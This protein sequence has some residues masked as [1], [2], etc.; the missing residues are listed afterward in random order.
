MVWM[1]YSVDR[2]LTKEPCRWM[3]AKI[4]LRKNRPVRYQCAVMERL[5]S[6]FLY[7]T[8]SACTRRDPP[9]P[10]VAPPLKTKFS[11]DFDE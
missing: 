11:H 7:N 4:S 3:D 5:F 1:N 2:Y 6:D 8:R 10:G 9:P